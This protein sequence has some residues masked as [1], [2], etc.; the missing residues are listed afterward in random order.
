MHSEEVLT[1]AV[2]SLRKALGDD[3]KT[4]RFIKTVPR[5]GYHML[6][7]AEASAEK[8]PSE[9]RWDVLTQRVGLRFLIIAA[10]MGF[11]FLVVLLQVIVELVYLLGQ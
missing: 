6:Q 7:P 11:V 5:Y 1:V 9:N 3:P 8:A 2:S 10:L 4:P